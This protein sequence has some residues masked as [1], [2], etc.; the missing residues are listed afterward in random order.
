MQL[1]E[2]TSAEVHPHT[3]THT[4]WLEMNLQFR[5][6]FMFFELQIQFWRSSVRFSPDSDAEQPISGLFAYE[7]YKLSTFL[8]SMYSDFKISLFIF[9]GT[10]FHFVFVFLLN[11]EHKQTRQIDLNRQNWCWNQCHDTQTLIITWNII[12]PRAFHS[13]FDLPSAALAKSH[14]MQ[15]VVV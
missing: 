12:G 9:I 13:H 5:I 10:K 1:D 4:P 11:L 3:H 8:M 7:L 15:Y 2:L 6:D 14:N